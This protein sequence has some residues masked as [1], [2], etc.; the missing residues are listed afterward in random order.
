MDA[1]ILR[2]GGSEVEVRRFET[3]TGVRLRVT[4]VADGRVLDLDPLELEGLTRLPFTT[5]PG[6]PGV[7]LD[8][9]STRREGGAGGVEILRNEF[10]LVEVRVAGRPDPP[11]L[12]VRSLISGVEVELRA[13]HLQ[14]LTALRHRDLS[15]LI[16]PSGL[17]AATEPDPDQV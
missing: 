6:F 9:P 1:V 7:G 4:A 3:G 2:D 13:E 8:D 15:P 17:V 16:D 5:L 12:R 11:G 14:R 10:A